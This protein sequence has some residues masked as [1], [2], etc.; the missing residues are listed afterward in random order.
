M[1]KTLTR[2]LQHSDSRKNTLKQFTK[3]LR[4]AP[5]IDHEERFAQLVLSRSSPSKAELNGQLTNPS[6]VS[7]QTAHS[8]EHTQ[9][10]ICRR[11]PPLRTRSK[12]PRSTSR[13][14]LQRNSSKTGNLL[15]G[16][17]KL[18][19]T[20]CT[21]RLLQNSKT[22]NNE[23]HS[24]PARNDESKPCKTTHGTRIKRITKNQ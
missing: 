8:I 9:L 11:T 22:K 17:E 13:L 21:R 7:E 19:N 14:L 3:N 12:I 18:S 15:N 2:I 10:S 23:Q 5:R 20:N 16:T 6:F 4:T 24:P 1:N